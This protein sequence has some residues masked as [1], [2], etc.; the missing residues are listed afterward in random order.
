METWV[1]NRSLNSTSRIVTGLNNTIVGICQNF[2]SFHLKA[3][4]GVIEKKPL[5][6]K[7]PYMSI[8]R[9]QKLNCS[10]PEGLLQANIH[11]SYRAKDTI[12]LWKQHQLQA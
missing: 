5:V 3:V 2:S 4:R 8:N 7:S 6:P 9:P 10:W 1:S 12:R 11:E